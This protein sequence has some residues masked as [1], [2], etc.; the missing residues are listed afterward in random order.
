MHVNDAGSAGWRRNG[1]LETRSGPLQRLSDSLSTRGS[2]TKEMVPGMT[3]VM[4]H[5]HSVIAENTRGVL[6]EKLAGFPAF[7]C[8]TNA[9][10]LEGRQMCVAGYSQGRG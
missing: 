3:M 4:S 10:T 5:S 7:Y 9:V 6:D 2:R 1:T 8:W